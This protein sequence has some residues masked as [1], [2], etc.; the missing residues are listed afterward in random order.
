MDNDT[1]AAKSF[2]RAV[3]T[4]CANAKPATQGV[5][6]VETTPSERLDITKLSQRLY[7][8]RHE[9]LTVMAAAGMDS[10]TDPLEQQRIAIPTKEMLMVL[11]RRVGFESVAELRRDGAPIWADY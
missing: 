9:V 1:A 10:M 5:V 4:L 7:G 2:Y 8:T 6:F 3:R 11:K